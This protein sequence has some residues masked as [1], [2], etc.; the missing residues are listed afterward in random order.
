MPRARVPRVLYVVTEAGSWDAPPERGSHY[1]AYLVEAD[2]LRATGF[3][4]A[5]GTIAKTRRYTLA[6]EPKKRAAR[7][8]ER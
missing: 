3:A 6:P 7:K 8:G 1:A 5:C 4:N 2:A